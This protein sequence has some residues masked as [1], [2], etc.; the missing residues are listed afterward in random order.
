MR[1]KLSQF[2]SS[3]IEV[4]LLITKILNINVDFVRVRIQTELRDNPQ[5]MGSTMSTPIHRLGLANFAL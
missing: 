1:F 3:M 5:L 2:Y 4:R